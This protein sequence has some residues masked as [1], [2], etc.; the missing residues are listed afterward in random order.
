MD[1]FIVIAV[2]GAVLLHGC[3][4]LRENDEGWS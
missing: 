1:A 3:L 4:W 2:V